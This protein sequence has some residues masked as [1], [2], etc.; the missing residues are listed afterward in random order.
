SVAQ[1]SSFNMF[2]YPFD[3]DALSS[4]KMDTTGFHSSLIWDRTYVEYIFGEGPQTGKFILLHTLRQINDVRAVEEFNK[5]YI[6]FYG[7]NSPARIDARVIV[8]GKVVFTGD[9][10]STS[11]VEEESVKY[12]LMALE[13]VTEGCMIESIVVLPVDFDIVGSHDLQDEVP[14]LESL[15]C[16][17]V[18]E[19]VKLKYK[20]YNAEIPIEEK[21]EGGRRIIYSL[22][23]NSPAIQ[24][25]E[26]CHVDARVVRLDHTLDNIEGT[27]Y[28]G[29]NWA[30]RG[31]NY[32]DNNWAAYEKSKSGLKK[33]IKQ[34]KFDAL[35]TEQEKIFAVEDY[36]KKNIGI[37]GGV[38]ASDDAT[39]AL[40][41]KVVNHFGF[42]RLMFLTYYELG[43]PCEMVV[44][45]KR[46]QR[47]F[48][49]DFP[50]DF[51]F[52]DV[53]FYFPNTKQ[54]VDPGSITMRSPIID[55]EFLGQDAVR[56]KLVDLSGAISGVSSIKPIPANPYDSSVMKERFTVRFADDKQSTVEDYFKS[57]SGFA[58]LGIRSLCYFATDEERTEF[59]ENFIKGN[60]D[61]SKVENIKA[62]NYDLSNQ[63]EYNAP[64]ELTATITGPDLLEF[65]GEKILLKIGEVIGQQSE[66]YNTKPRQMGIDIETAHYYDRVI[67]VE[68]PD[69]YK[70]EGLDALVKDTHVK[71]SNEKDQAYFTSNYKIE[72]NKLIINITESYNALEI[73]ISGYTDF[74]KVVNAAADF[75]KIT[76][77]LSKI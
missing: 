19:V 21:V 33:F 63:K 5:I 42:N 53:L 37:D 72:G 61:N 60:F 45:C 29:L 51:G 66:L 4:Q 17:V 64:L 75:N 70:L 67:T 48:D 73:P 77:V 54:Y 50:S 18:P 47:K 27:N 46:S 71:D 6:P 30:D 56:I 25:E 3:D 1:N 32:F 34:Q 28:V 14:S 23:M 74:A 24:D 31:I 22:M 36:L 41:S 7:L 15:V 10:T 16:I 13:G 12:R 69:G 55:S 9:N 39:D 43:I 38:S 57:Y 35:A 44:T 52:T 40:K 8:N 59:L 65:A 62:A 2:D 76:L 58:E 20:V 11:I 26:Y 49:K 68:I